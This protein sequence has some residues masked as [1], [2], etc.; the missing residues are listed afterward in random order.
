MKKNFI[1]LQS[2]GLSFNNFVANF[3]IIQIHQ[4][5]QQGN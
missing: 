2:L 1:S 5:S 3:K 4:L